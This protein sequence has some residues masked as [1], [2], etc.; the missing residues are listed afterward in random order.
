MKS[1]QVLALALSLSASSISFGADT[2]PAAG[3]QSAI[4]IGD[5]IERVARE[6]GR[7]F[8]VDPR[9]RAEVP[10]T[11]LDVKRVDYD[12]LLAILRVH[13]FIAV[14]EKGFVTVVPDSGARQL[15]VKTYYDLAF[16]EGD[17]ELVTVLLA[18]KNVC[19]AHSVPVL[20]PLMPQAAHLAA[21][22]QANVLIIN[23][24]AA[25]ARRIGEM[26]EKL[27]R[28]APSGARC[29]TDGSSK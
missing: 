27:D 22:P 21:L 23:D 11:G 20:R 25:N 26:F 17:D 10:T 8:V 15:P 24:R 19:A 7:Q 3:A 5:L 18:A 1:M 29:G 9:V 4:P 16:K 28:L 13:A 6:T 12:R 14:Q 2:P